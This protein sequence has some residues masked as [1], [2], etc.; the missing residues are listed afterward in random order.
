M[1]GLGA[2]PPSR[3]TA[4]LRGMRWRAFMFRGSVWGGESILP[5]WNG[6][7]ETLI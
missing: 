6:R 2:V 1:D 5:R 7:L 4:P 3:F